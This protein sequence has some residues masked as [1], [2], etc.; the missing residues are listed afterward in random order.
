MA[1][2]LTSLPDDPKPNELEIRF[3]HADRIE[4]GPYL[5]ALPLIAGA[6][7]RKPEVRS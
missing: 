2:S 3:Y 7:P 6:A 4:P 1:G 5:G